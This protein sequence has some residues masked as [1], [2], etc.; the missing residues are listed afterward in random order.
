MP[1]LKLGVLD[2]YTLN[3]FLYATIRNGLFNNPDQYNFEKVLAHKRK[4]L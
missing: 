4:L 2:I 3:I 1:T